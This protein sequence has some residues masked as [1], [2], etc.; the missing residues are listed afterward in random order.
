MKT[1]INMLEDIAAEVIENTC[2]LEVIYRN[3]N[4]DVETDCAIACLIRSL[5]KTKERIDE[6]VDQLIK[7]KEPTAADKNN[8][9]DS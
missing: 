4:E 7:T 3:S 8:N 6:Y 9:A 2:L 1:P 5:Y